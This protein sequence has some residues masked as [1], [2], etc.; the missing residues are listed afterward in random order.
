MRRLA[1]LALLLPVAAAGGDA[2]DIARAI[3]ENSFDRDECYRV[4]DLTLTRE[5]IR[6]FLADGHMIFSRPVAG[7]RTAA[8]FVADTD[9]G[10]AEVLLLPPDRAERRSLAAFT[11]SPNLNEHFQTGLFLFTGD[12][13]ATLKVQMA[14]NPANRKSPEM[15]PLLDEHWT[16]ALRNLGASYQTRITLDLL[17]NPA[18]RGGL[19]A[20]MLANS[21][22]GAFD[23]IYDPDVPDQILAGKTTARGERLFFDTWTNFPARSARNNPTPA[24]RDTTAGDYRIEATIDPDLS[25]TA[26]TRVKVRPAVDRLAATAFDITPQMQVS[27]VT[28][29][30][31]P[32][33]VLQREAL[34]ADALRGGNELLL[35]IP[36]EPLREG[37]EYEFEFHHSGKVILDA[38]DR[39]FYVS[40]RGNW[41]PAQGFQFSS[42]DLL[43]RYPRDLDL[44]TPGDVVE[45][46]T[47][48]E[49]RITRRRTSAPIRMAGFNL[50][51][52]DRVRVT[53]GG[54]EVDVCANRTLET[55]LQP[56][57]PPPPIP[58]LPRGPARRTAPLEDV[59]PP[60][61][62]PAMRLQQLAAEVASALEFMAS[63]FGPPALPRLTVSPIPGA[64]GQGFPGLIYLSTLSYLKDLPSA[65]AASQQQELFFEDVL[66]AHEM[67][68]QWWGNR[69]GAAAYRDSWLMEALA[70]YS[71]LLYLEK[72]KG[73]H[74]LE[75]ILESYRQDLLQKNESGQTV[76]STGPIV[77]GARLE[78]SI[79]PRA[80]RSITYGK[81]S[82][83]VHM[84][85]TRMGDE[86]F[87][88][89]LAA[90][91]RR[92]DRQEISTEEFREFAAGF[93]PPRNDD[94]KLEAFFDQ[95]VY[96]TG[97]PSL[98]LAWTLKGKAPNLR[99][100]G[101]L[102]QSGVDPD[103]T[104]LAPVEVQL[105]RGRTT[106]QWVRAGA[107]PVT[108]TVALQQAPLKVTLDP[109]NAT[110]RK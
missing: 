74:E 98:K 66:Q 59:P 38:G 50:G 55:A 21:R 3:R 73:A 52:Y 53:R 60:P 15:G 85:R 48:G 107:D 16:P 27:G 65:H 75:V 94:P 82:W 41:Y 56:K 106:T 57:V 29:D 22:L 32:A 100:V 46:R 96:G 25:M 18:R 13:Y 37:R 72:S 87:F 31:R 20:A 1:F 61:A 12:V 80:W 89:M 26:V 35:V 102:T 43:F 70:N 14:G 7:R 69:I 40:A 34:R 110:L 2:G 97:I 6:I 11:N 92:Y 67:A 64:F 39:V 17:D 49:Q 63:K 68:H 45:D 23:V 42:Y 51:D 95:W 77:L 78:N 10:D 58:T 88:A 24:P 83:I 44:V 30:G 108:F 103:F 90:L 84:L 33:E 105:A 62:T 8:V 47:E 91:L 28:V 19:F 93:L 54:Y 71:A 99:L 104:A 9:G 101:T 109:H 36:S 76:D 79:E 5:D 81:G 4:R 86:R